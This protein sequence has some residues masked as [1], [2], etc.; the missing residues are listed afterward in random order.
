MF[1]DADRPIVL[2]VDGLD[3]AEASAIDNAALPLGL[4]ASLPDG[5]YVV[6]TVADSG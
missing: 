6:A 4:P 2:V 5:V 1:E 3:E